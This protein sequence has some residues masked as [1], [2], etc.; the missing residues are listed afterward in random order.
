M[1]SRFGDSAYAMEELVA[2]L[3]SAF[4]SISLGVTHEPR[5]D[6]AK[7]LNNWMQVLNGDARAFSNAASKAQAAADYLFR[8]QDRIVVAA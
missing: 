6:H 5:A 2:E 3:S 8:L 1:K 7:Y 4:L